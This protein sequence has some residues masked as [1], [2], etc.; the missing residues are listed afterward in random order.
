MYTCFFNNILIIT[1]RLGIF[2][3][4]HQDNILIK[5]KPNFFSQIVAMWKMVIIIIICRLGIFMS[6]SEEGKKKPRYTRNWQNKNE[7]SMS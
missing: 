2:I 7:T 6:L 1:C 3:S 4:P 5:I